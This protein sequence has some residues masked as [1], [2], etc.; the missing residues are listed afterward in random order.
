MHH[1]GFL[2]ERTW[3]VHTGSG[4]SHVATKLSKILALAVNTLVHMSG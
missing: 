1:R 3:V 4:V 2:W